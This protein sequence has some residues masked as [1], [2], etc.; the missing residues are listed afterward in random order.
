MKEQVGAPYPEVATAF[1]DAYD[2]RPSR[3]DAPCD[4]A[5]FF[6]LKERWNLAVKFAEIASNLKPNDDVLF[7]DHAAYQWRSR[8]EWSI[9]AYWSGDFALSAK[10][11]RELLASPALP[12]HERARVQ[13]NL[14]FAEGKL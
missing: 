4:A 8:D 5:R 9:A 2:F 13:K 14:E 3:A 11:C 1:L 7:V 12:D 6:R 10:L